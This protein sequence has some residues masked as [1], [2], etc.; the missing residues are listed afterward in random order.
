MLTAEQNDR[1]TQVG[2]GTPMGELMRRYWQPIAVAS[3]LDDNP[4][5]KIRILGEDL[6]LYRDLSGEMGLIRPNCAHRLVNMEFGIPVEHGIRCPYHGWCYDASGQCTDT[7]F[8]PA[9]SKLKDNVNIG[10][11]P[12]QTLGG[13]V[14]AYLGPDPAPLLPKW[15]FLMLENS[16]RQV[17]VTIV[18]CN[19]L[20]CHENSADPYHNTYCHGYFFKYQLERM[21][22]TNTR[23][24]DQT[25]HRA[26]TSIDSTKGHDGVVFERDVYGFKKGVRYST[27]KGADSDRVQW[28]PYNI[29]PFY[30]GSISGGLRSMVNM[31]IPMDDEHTLHFQYM[32]YHA[33]GVEAP[34]QES[35]PYFDVPL[36]D[37]SGKPVLDFVLAQ[38]M[39]CWYAQGTIVDRTR[40]TLGATDIAIVQFRNI[41]EEQMQRVEAGEDPINVFRDAADM[42]DVIDVGGRISSQRA[43]VLTPSANRL[44]VSRNAFHLGYF[45]DDA[46]RYGP[47]TPLAMDLMRRAHELAESADQLSRV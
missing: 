44:G 17:G 21:G 35:V 8:E 2:P 38:D 30:S 32:I 46:D 1:L 34:V 4:V 36:Y 39:A 45:Q 22:V 6:V 27:E 25:M 28:F 13:L 16:I 24:A 37:E 10:G 23:A 31:R 7:P 40:E 47:A 26:F 18:P 29:F 43:G 42:G 41:L 9:N 33:E 5:K 15:D 19:W 20:Q 12:V 3:M 11:F 14:F